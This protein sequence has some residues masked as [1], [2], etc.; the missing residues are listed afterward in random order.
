[1]KGSLLFVFL[2]TA[3]LDFPFFIFHLSFVIYDSQ[4]TPSARPLTNRQASQYTTR[5]KSSSMTNDKWKMTNGKSRT[6]TENREISF[7]LKPRYFFS[8]EG[9][10]VTLIFTAFRC[11]VSLPESSSS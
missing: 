6:E 8:S 5:L 11:S 4:R 1:L 10:T 2:G 3:S 7:D 9:L